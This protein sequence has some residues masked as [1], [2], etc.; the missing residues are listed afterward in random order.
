MRPLAVKL[1]S[2]LE[3]RTAG[4]RAL[5]RSQP[6]FAIASGLVT[7]LVKCPCPLI[8]HKLLRANQ[9]GFC[10]NVTF[11]PPNRSYYKYGE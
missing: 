6:L 9:I 3:N 4:K 8:P 2:H 7:A 11:T 1:L 5:P 10:Q